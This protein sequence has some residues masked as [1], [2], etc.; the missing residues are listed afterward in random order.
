MSMAMATAWSIPGCTVSDN[1]SF[2][3]SVVF[4]GPP[5]FLL[6]YKNSTCLNCMHYTVHHHLFIIVLGAW[7]VEWFR[8]VGVSL[9]FAAALCSLMFIGVGCLRVYL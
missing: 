7:I 2:P 5:L 8:T 4:L 9:K 3:S 6:T 1:T